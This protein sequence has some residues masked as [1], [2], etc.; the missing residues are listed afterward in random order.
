MKNILV[1]GGGG[2]IGQAI[3]RKL[4][5]KG[6][7]V[8]VVGR[9]CYPHLMEIGVRC[10]QGDIRD[11]DFLQ[12]VFKGVDTVFHVAAK[13]GIWGAEEE[14]FAINTQGTQNVIAACKDASVPVLV[15]TST[16]SV[17]FDRAPLKGADERLPYASRPL[18]HYAASKIEAEKIVLAA[19]GKGL[20]TT[21]IR[22]HLVWGPGD[23]HLIPRLLERGRQG[24]LKVVGKGDN[25]VDISYIDNVVHAHI[26]AAENL[27]AG[28]SAGGQA[29]FIGQEQ[30][31][32]LWEWINSLYARLDIEQIHKKVPFFVAYLA[33]GALEGIFG[34]ARCTTEP[35]MTRFL[36][37]QLAHSHWFN[38]EKAERILGYKEQ[39]ST[40]EGMGEL[41]SWLRREAV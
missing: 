37:H 14:Y 34:L 36:A 22:P 26:L 8:N 41:V 4:I 11:L 31:V 12:S 21:A 15:Y 19:N 9:N 10:H 13:A 1:T 28:G 29:F 38:H 33:G 16:P 17:V 27:H 3:V 39:V 7:Q 2:F 40:A 23:Q 32:L 20:G 5:S 24:E 18:C 6:L 30:P 25:V 35:K